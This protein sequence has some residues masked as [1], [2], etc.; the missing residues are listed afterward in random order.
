[1]SPVGPMLI[2][3][4]FNPN[5]KKGKYIFKSTKELVQSKSLE[6]ER[7]KKAAKLVW[8]ALVQHPSL[9]RG[10]DRGGPQPFVR[11]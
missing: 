4:F 10:V 3:S 8:A 9:V 1:M 6:G 7:E 11:M 2:S 5:R